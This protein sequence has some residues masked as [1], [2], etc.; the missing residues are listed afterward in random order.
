MVKAVCEAIE[1]ESKR[2]KRIKKIYTSIVKPVVEYLPLHAHKVVD[3]L[4]MLQ[5]I[6]SLNISIYQRC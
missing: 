1:N 4:N 5:T 3:I 6:G 2:E